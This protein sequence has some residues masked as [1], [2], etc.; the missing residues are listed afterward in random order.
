[1]LQIKEWVSKN[2]VVVGIFVG[3]IVIGGIFTISNN[4]SHSNSSSSAPSETVSS[5]SPEEERL[6]REAAEKEKRLAEKVA[7]VEQY[8][9][10]STRTDEDKD[11]YKFEKMIRMAGWI[12]GDNADTL[13]ATWKYFGGEGDYPKTVT[14]RDMVLMGTFSIQ[15]VTDGF[16]IS[17]STP[18]SGV[19]HYGYLNIGTDYEDPDDDRWVKTG[20]FPRNDD[21]VIHYSSGDSSNKLGYSD[22][23]DYTI[24]ADMKT[25][26]TWG[27]VQFS[28]I[29]KDAITPKY[30][31]GLP[32][33]ETSHYAVCKPLYCGN[34]QKTYLKKMANL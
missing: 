31:E 4:Q 9:T 1:M 3:I 24:K 26:N 25:Y 20:T 5:T 22:R 23:S 15:N 2:R 12:K 18:Y 30:P 34:V 33:F 6:Q 21:F 16:T 28:V 10:S 29:I 27:P 13:N 19:E 14:E 7:K 8:V 11:G 32:E 17:E